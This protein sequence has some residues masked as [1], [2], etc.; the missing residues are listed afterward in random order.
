MVKVA[1]KVGG[2][3]RVIRRIGSENVVINV[4]TCLFLVDWGHRKHTST[5][6]PHAAVIRRTIHLSMITLPIS[7]QTQ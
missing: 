5:S 2:V 4:E 1:E 3:G 6:L 7:V